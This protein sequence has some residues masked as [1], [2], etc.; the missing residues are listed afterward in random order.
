M[1]IETLSREVLS[2]KNDNE[3]KGILEIYTK[4]QIQLHIYPDECYLS[5]NNINQFYLNFPK[6]KNIIDKLDSFFLKNYD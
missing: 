1:N 6:V 4:D 2:L 3:L 5:N